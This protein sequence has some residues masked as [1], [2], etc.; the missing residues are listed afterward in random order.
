MPNFTKIRPV[1]AELFHVDRRTDGRWG[2]QTNMTKLMVAFHNF[3]KASNKGLDLKKRYI[4]PSLQAD[5]HTA[6]RTS[7]RI[8]DLCSEQY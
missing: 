4:F 1:G 6:S 8:P 2:R 3:A 5:S 7:L